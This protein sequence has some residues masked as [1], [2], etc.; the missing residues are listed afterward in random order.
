MPIE[1]IPADAEKG[2]PI[3]MEEAPADEPPAKRRR[4]QPPGAKNEPRATTVTPPREPIAASP[5]PIAAPPEPA[6]PQPQD[7]PLP[8]PRAKELRPRS[9]TPG[10]PGVVVKQYDSPPTPERR[11]HTAAPRKPRVAEKRDEAPKSSMSR[12]R[13]AYNPSTESTKRVYMLPVKIG[14]APCLKD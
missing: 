8:T 13:R 1:L 14:T 5:E 6:A 4:G 12:K 11:T 10:K 2:V 3:S 7:E 9:A